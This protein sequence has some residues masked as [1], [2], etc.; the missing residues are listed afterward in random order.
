MCD[1]GFDRD[2]D[3]KIS[4]CFF[5]L[6]FV[7]FSLYCGVY[8]W[9][10]MCSWFLNRACKWWWAKEMNRENEKD[11]NNRSHKLLIN[12]VTDVV[13]FLYLLK[14]KFFRS[15]EVNRYL[16]NGTHTIFILFTRTHPVHYSFGLF[17]YNSFFVLS[18]YF[19]YSHPVSRSLLS[20]FSSLSLF[21][22]SVCLSVSV[23][24][25]HIAIFLFM[26]I[27]SVFPFILYF[28]Q[29]DIGAKIESHLLVWHF[30]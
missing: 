20:N 12:H 10:K 29:F 26:Y 9:S 17:L 19:L 28:H 3:L 25:S 23:P 30:K 13:C 16:A 6:F 4:L 1:Y 14:K 8:F 11:R 27:C 5:F 15:R 18:F 24:V 2:K 7:F 22:F 21:I